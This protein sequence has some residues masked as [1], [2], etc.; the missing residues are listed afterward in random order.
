QEVRGAELA[1]RVR[2]GLRAT[3]ATYQIGRARVRGNARPVPAAGMA[4]RPSGDT[5]SSMILSSMRVS[6]MIATS[7]RVWA[8]HVTGFIG[9]ER[10]LALLDRMLR[11]V[12]AGG[13][14]GRPGR[15]F[16]IRGRRRV[17]K[18][19]LAEEFVERTSVPY[20]FFTAS[21]QRT[22]AEDLALFTEAVTQSNLPGAAVFDDQMPGSWDAA[23]RLLAS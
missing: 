5:L 20:L 16:L 17:G 18:S 12:T 13:R 14:A 11:R 10:E 8:V 15:A 1:E 6:S 3:V 23:L 22:V 4:S 9:R 7:L 21:A 2:P 19:R